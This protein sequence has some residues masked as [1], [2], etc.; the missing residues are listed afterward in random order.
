MKGTLLRRLARHDRG[1]AEIELALILPILVLLLSGFLEVGRAYWQAQ[2]VEKGLRAGLSWLARTEDPT[3]PGNLAAA[4][5]IVR[6]GR[7]DGAAPPLV[8]GWSR[9]GA[10]LVPA[11]SNAAVGETVVPVLRFTA[12]VPFDPILP[13]LAAFVGLDSFNIVLS[14]EQPW[15]GR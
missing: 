12:T 6:T 4:Q 2:A 7:R 10:S 3:A 13:D 9:P 15:T 1:A 8:S 14:H 5:N 11:V